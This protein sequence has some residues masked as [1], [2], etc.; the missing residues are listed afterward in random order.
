M[1]SVSLILN[2]G[3]RDKCLE[4]LDYILNYRG[5]KGTYIQYSIDDGKLRIWISGAESEA[6]VTKHVV[7]KAYRE[8]RALDAWRR[9][10]SGVSI[11]LL[12]KTVGKPFVSEAL[13]EVLK[14][15][16]YEA[17]LSSGVLE[18]NA[19]PDEVV[20][21][22]KELAEALEKVVKF[23][24]RAS[25][26]AKALVTAYSVITGKDPLEVIKELEDTGFLEI[27]GYRVLIKEEWRSLLRRLAS[28][29]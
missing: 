23:R 5:L 10:V 18:T 20:R 12:I 21:V 28:R 24:P 2:C 27:R 15:L 26:A 9:G 4:L 1:G 8:W 6:L 7:M 16:G 11:N 29:I 17:E 13:T 3:N 14:M 19:P 25:Y 22:A